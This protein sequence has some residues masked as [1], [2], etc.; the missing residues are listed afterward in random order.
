M[1]QIRVLDSLVASRIAAG[2]VIDRPA[3]I[4]RELIDNAIDAGPT[5]ITVDVRGGGSEYLS[6]SD[7][8][9]GIRKEDLPLTVKP[10]ATSKIATLDDLY[11]LSTMGFRGEALY[12]IAAVSTLSISSGGWTY[13]CDNSTEGTLTKGGTE[14][15]TVVTSQNLFAQLP[16]R[17]AFLKRD[18]SEA[19]LIRN[20]FLSKAMPF[21]QIHFRYYANGALKIDLPVR[22][23]LRDR[24]LDIM[25]IDERLI[26]SE[27]T[28]LETKDAVFTIKAVTSLP[29]LHRSDRSKIKIYVNSRAVEEYSLVQ[30][31]S[32]GYGESLPGGSFPY[33]VIFIDEDPELVD[34]NIHPAKKEVKLRNRAAVHHALSSMIADG[35]PKAIPA[36]KAEQPELIPAERKTS[37]Q[38][39][40]FIYE[41]SAPDDTGESVESRRSSY[42]PAEDARPKNRDWIEKAREISSVKPAI[43]QSAESKEEVWKPESRKEIRYIGQAFRLFL[44]CECDGRLY[45]VDQ[46]AAHERVIFDELRAQKTVQKL[47]IPIPFEVS[48]D[49]DDFLLSHSDVYTQFGI[50]ISRTGDREWSLSALPALA[51]PFEK[52]LIELIGTKAGSDSEL[53]S[54]LYAVV[55]CRAAIKAGDEVD[56][57]SAQALLEK[58]FE[59]ENPACPHGRTFIV[60]LEEEELRKMV[61]RTK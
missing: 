30:A 42:R 22:K 11:H 6:V 7:N 20:T 10:H 26:R 48:P 46:H 40:E 31:V 54:A 47:L 35:L 12:S 43:R 45:L 21:Y 4:A 14:R 37:F 33:S 51:R 53:E 61:G 2:E 57:Y 25:T 38:D 56:A 59:L 52:E 23:T 39:R 19:Q 16:A 5:E 32:F 27:F 17:R 8:G 28:Y 60:T 50:M 49:M 24:V 3:A 13:T 29:S 36:I 55:A 44:I 58:V 34:F 15:G 18:Q 9:S 41:R 1:A